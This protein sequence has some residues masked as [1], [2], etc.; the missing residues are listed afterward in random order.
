MFALIYF[1]PIHKAATSLKEKDVKLQQ[2]TAQFEL[3]NFDQA[4]CLIKQENIDV[5]TIP[6]IQNYLIEFCSDLEVLDKKKQEETKHDA[7][8]YLLQNLEK[9]ALEDFYAYNA[10]TILQNGFVAILEFLR[11]KGVNL[12]FYRQNSSQD[13]FFEACEEYQQNKAADE[14]LQFF[15]KHVV[16]IN[17][18]NDEQEESLFF[19]CLHNEKISTNCIETLIKLGANP[20]SI[21]NQ[22]NFSYP[23]STLQYVLLHSYKN[24]SPRNE[25]LIKLLSNKLSKHTKIDACGI[26]KRQKIELIKELVEQEEFDQALYFIRRKENNKTGNI[27][28]HDLRFMKHLFDNDYNE[29]SDLDKSKRSKF[30]ETVLEKYD[31]EEINNFLKPIF[32]FLLR[33]NN[34]EFL[35]IFKKFEIEWDAPGSVRSNILNHP[36]VL[37]QIKFE[38][39]DILINS[40]SF[41][42]NKSNRNLLFQQAIQKIDFEKDLDNR[43]TVMKILKEASEKEGVKLDEIK[44]SEKQQKTLALLKE[45]DKKHRQKYTNALLETDLVEDLNC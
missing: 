37:D 12:R 42:V 14:T 7:L 3:K 18:C 2:I 44:F 34:I 23:I 5:S 9:A 16:D 32:P 13:A 28:L 40:L 21:S 24:H 8:I 19:Q 26:I 27:V 45:E 10:R 15:C 38:C 22:A 11:N 30:V 36:W 6:H 4:V 39:L 20:R 25:S 17:K 33:S 1:F 41:K 29:Y 43:L 35:E 31:K